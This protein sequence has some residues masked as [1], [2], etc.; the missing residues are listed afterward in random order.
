MFY[1]YNFVSVLAQN[2]GQKLAKQLVFFLDITPFLYL[3]ENRFTSPAPCY[4]LMFGSVRGT[5]YQN[6]GFERC[7]L[8]ASNFQMSFDYWR[9]NNV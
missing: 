9:G 5:I 7:L 3:T 8:A 4:E 6:L 2:P 1:G